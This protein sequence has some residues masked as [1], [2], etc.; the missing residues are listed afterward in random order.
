MDPVSPLTNTQT[1]AA[2]TTLKTCLDKARADIAEA[3]ELEPEILD[4]IYQII[5]KACKPVL[6]QKPAKAAA[7]PASEAKGAKTR[8]PMSAYNMFVREQFRISHEEGGKEKGT[9]NSQQIMSTVSGQWATLSAEEKEK[10]VQMAN[11]A[12]TESG[13]E[14]KPTKTKAAADGG[15]SRRLT[16][17]NLFYR[18]HKDEIKANKE[19]GL[20]TMKAVGQAWKA[21]TE[22]ERTEYNERA[23]A[24]GADE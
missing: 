21:L 23:A 11:E 9:G 1:M 4:S 22:A 5:L 10:Y 20:T 6:D 24:A 17:Y 16:G 13:A 2:N 15:K 7:A 3:Y 14:P 18:E 12:N 8:R 19:E